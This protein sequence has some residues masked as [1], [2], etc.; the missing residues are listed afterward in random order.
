MD[1]IKFEYKPVNFRCD[2]LHVDVKDSFL[3][4]VEA[5]LEDVG[6]LEVTR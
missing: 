3:E 1:R 2:P 6:E 5:L 4:T